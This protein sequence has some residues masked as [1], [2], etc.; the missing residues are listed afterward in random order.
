VFCNLVVFDAI[1]QAEYQ[2]HDHILLW[3]REIMQPGDETF[4]SHRWLQDSLPK[5]MIYAYLYSDLLEHQCPRRR[6]LDVGGG[7]TAL[8]R[9][10]NRQHDYWLMDILAH[11]PPEAMR[12]AEM[13]LGR[14]FW[15]NMDWHDAE[16][17]CYDIVIANDLFP[18][19]DQRLALFIRKF[20]P[21][22]TEMR[23]SL[24]YY[25]TER[26]YRVRR[27]DADEVFHILAW[28]APQVC[29]ALEPY[30]DQFVRSDLNELLQD[31]PSLFANGRQVC[32]IT[33]RGGQK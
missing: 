11:D 26:W 19:V 25:N 21:G 33:L 8:T 12:R 7:F 24:T 3:L 16:P 29:K 30:A 23:L 17:A 13:Q 20:L 5:R 9:R 31:R 6:V 4:A 28:D 18:N 27:T 1:R 2:T 32:A 22:C 10:L 14:A 15:I